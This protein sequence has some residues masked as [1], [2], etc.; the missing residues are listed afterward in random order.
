M[1]F[2]LTVFKLIIGLVSHILNEYFG[3]II[4]M[5]VQESR[6]FEHFMTYERCC[7]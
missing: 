1:I 7:C 3:I 4:V 2:N 6:N 5:Q